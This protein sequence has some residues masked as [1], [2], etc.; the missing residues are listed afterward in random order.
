MTGGPGAA[1]YGF[2][3]FYVSCI[4]LTWWFYLRKG[5]NMPC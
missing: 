5:A 4:V 3:I 1:L 2:V